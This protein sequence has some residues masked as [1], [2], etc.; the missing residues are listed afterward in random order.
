V[1]DTNG[2]PKTIGDFGDAPTTGYATPWHHYATTWS[3]S[4]GVAYFK[5]YRDGAQVW[6]T[7]MALPHLVTANY[8]ALGTLG[9]GSTPIFGDDAAPI[10]FF[11]GGKIADFR[12][13]NYQLNSNAVHYLYIA[14]TS[15]QPAPPSNIRIQSHSSL[16]PSSRF[17][18]GLEYSAASLNRVNAIPAGELAA[19]LAADR[20]RLAQPEFSSFQ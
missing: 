20:R 10:T 17:L 14:P 7:N 11:F 9:R 1:S 18:P 4:N 8:L 13:Y 5:G 12:I 16:T 19:V 15:T 2:S 6:Q 3:N